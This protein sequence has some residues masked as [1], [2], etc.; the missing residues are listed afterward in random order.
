MICDLLIGKK[1]NIQPE[2]SFQTIISGIKNIITLL[3]TDLLNDTKKLETISY[4]SNILNIP[5]G[6]SYDLEITLDSK[7]IRI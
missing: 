3:K 7:K 2:I 5:K 1:R 4:W 6:W